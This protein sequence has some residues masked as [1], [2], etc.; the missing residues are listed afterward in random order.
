[1]EKRRNGP[2]TRVRARTLGDL[3][4]FDCSLLKAR[5]FAPSKKD[6]R[7]VPARTGSVRARPYKNKKIGG[8]S[9]LQTR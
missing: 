6:K 8:A 5:K 1:M 3:F 4:F 9:K 7:A 2:M